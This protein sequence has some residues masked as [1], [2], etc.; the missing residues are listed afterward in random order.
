MTA[1]VNAD[2]EIRT[3]LARIAQLA[4]GGDLD[5]YL[6][7]FTE[8][9][10]WAM[11]DNPSVGMLA[12][13]KRGHAEIRAGAEERRASGLQGPGTQ[14]RHVL[15]TVAVDLQSDDRATVRSYFLFVVDTT[16]TPSIR[17]MGQYDDVLVRAA[18]GWK[19]AHRTITVG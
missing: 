11:P 8:D 1:S 2:A 15:T 9:A 17:T 4:D 5:E 13:E 3:V 19:L 14:S 6:T 18:D 7:L 16:T 10:V 12:N